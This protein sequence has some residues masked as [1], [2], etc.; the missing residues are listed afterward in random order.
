MRNE[1]PGG[2]AVPGGR[3]ITLLI[4]ILSAYGAVAG[5]VFAFQRSLMYLPDR[6]VPR[7]AD[8]DA[9]DMTP[10]SLST[11]DGLELLAWYKPAARPQGPV[12]A[13]FHGNG[14][15]IGIRVYKVRPLL[16]AGF[17]VL[18][19]SWRGYGGNDGSPSEE[20]FHEDAEA[21]LA[22]LAGDGVAA[23]R[24]VLFGESLGSG[25]AV[26]LGAELAAAGTPV[27]GIVLEAPFTSAAATAQYHY[28][29]LP[30]YWLVLDRYESVRRIAG[31][32]AP[33]L[34]VHGE[35]DQVVPT[36]LGRRL[37][38]AAREPK[39]GVFLPEAGH[40]DLF[41]HG[42]AAVEVRFIRGLEGGPEQ[43]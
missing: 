20:G 4:V 6:S 1:A 14:G 16:D 24:V 26:R 31:V 13:Y 23:G 35:R 28:P 43:P 39:E 34:I 25:P 33:V 38:A 36:R 3:L 22:F 29:W 41:E 37:L 30:A 17:G 9:A 27:A 42:A 11:A 18:L 12:V 19:V 21:A 7:T 2:R 8:W 32:S 10:V 15:H 40:N 5:L